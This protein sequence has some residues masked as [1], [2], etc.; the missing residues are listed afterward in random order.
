[1]TW[2]S[3]YYATQ[4]TNHGGR[5]G[6][7]QQCRHLDRLVDFS[8]SDDFSSGHDN[9]SHSHH[10][11]E[12]HLQGLGL[13]SGQ[14]SS[15]DEYSTSST[16]YRAFEY[17]HHGVDIAQPLPSYYSDAGSS[18]HHLSYRISPTDIN[19]LMETIYLV[20]I[21]IAGMMIMMILCLL[22]IV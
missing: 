10:S 3:E 17:Y 8:S 16:E 4:D 19:I 2:N 6:I 20:S 15:T 18:G 12:G 11:L 7:S 9:Y 5:A 22:A 13:T 1:M 14:H 21:L